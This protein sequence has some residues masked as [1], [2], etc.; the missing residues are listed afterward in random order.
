M[1]TKFDILLQNSYVSPVL[2]I[3]QFIFA[4]AARHCVDIATHQ[5]GCCVL[6]K[7]IRY[8][9]G[10]YRQRL[11]AEISANALLLAQDKYGYY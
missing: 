9:S 2:C 3:V 8:S 4:A 5:H 6:P 11:V 1:C 7:C 10:E